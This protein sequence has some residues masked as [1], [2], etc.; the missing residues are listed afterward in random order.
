MLKRHPSELVWSRMLDGAL[1]PH[2][3]LWLSLHLRR[4]E[5]CR[6]AC[7]DMQAERAIFQS[8]PER[9]TEVQ[10]LVGQL[11]RG[12]SVPP[13]RP[14]RWVGYAAGAM[15]VAASAVVL[16]VQWPTV[17]DGLRAKGGDSFGLVVKHADT[18][19][20]L[21]ARCWPGDSLRAQLGSS[22]G[23]VLLVGIDPQGHVS[24]LHPF[25]GTE[26]TPLS[27]AQEFTPG[28]WVLDDAVGRE[29][30]VAVFSNARVTLEQVRAAV[31]RAGAATPQLEGA[32]SL[33][34]SC[35]KEAP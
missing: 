25:G 1:A 23:Y 26:S 11:P 2:E 35:A 14:H 4:C 18:V 12:P 22:H 3:R 24:A 19:T 17:E 5:V 33:E 32:V 27:E 7:A 10:Q 29:R 13:A 20:P 31:G 6:R 28:S 21:G 34:R 15:A 8:A 16:L 30:F 9:A